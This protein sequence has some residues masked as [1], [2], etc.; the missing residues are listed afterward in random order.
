[1]RKTSVRS[2]AI[3]LTMI[4][5]LAV[6]LS[7]QASHAW[8]SYHW[9]RTS[10]P[11]TVK[12]IDSMTSDWDDNL[13]VAISDWNSASVMNVV[14]EAGSDTT[15]V[16]KRCAAVAG[17]VHACNAAYGF[18][19]WLGLAQIW[20]SGGHIV[21]AIAKMNDS[22]LTSNLYSET[23]RQH[24]I[25][26]EVGHDWG[27]GHQSESGEDLNTCMDYSSALDNP[28]P[29][30]HDYAQLEAIYGAH[31]DSPTG[32]NRL[33]RGFLEADVQAE[34][35]WGEKVHENANGRSA[36]FV[37]DFGSGLQV[38]THVTWVQ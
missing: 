13:D 36:I 29:N 7:A 30:T 21:Q 1:M 17:K 3:L 24:V 34:A 5:L 20:T 32:G 22:Y 35:N 10:N 6:P 14:E 23:A 26:Q 37:K 33:P 27:L 18:N 11:F 15:K 4:L 25:C 16:R 8:G 28:S 9:A 12:V 2:G 19:G 38:V 31:S